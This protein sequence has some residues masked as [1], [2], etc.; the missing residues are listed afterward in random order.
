MP[1]RKL[2]LCCTTGCPFT[3][4]DG[5][6]YTQCNG[7]AMGSPLGV[8]RASFYMVDL[9]NKIFQ[10]DPSLKPSIYVSYVDDCFMFVKSDDHSEQIVCAFKENSVLIFTTETEI[11]KKRNFLDVHVNTEDGGFTTSVYKKETNKGIYI[12]ARSESPDR[13]KVNTIKNMINHT[14]KVC[15]PQTFHQPLL[16]LSRHLLVMVIQIL[17]STKF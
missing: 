6:I 16:C 13:Y 5:K 1:L 9:E 4:H 2:L 8:S 11:D 12:H 7:V 15:S 10:D 3:N 17:N 14:K